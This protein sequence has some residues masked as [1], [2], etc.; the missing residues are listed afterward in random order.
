MPS[1]VRSEVENLWQDAVEAEDPDA[2]RS[3]DWARLLKLGIPQL[4]NQLEF[5]SSL[6]ARFQVVHFAS[7]IL[8]NGL[9]R[10]IA[11]SSAAASRQSLR[12]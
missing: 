11:I 12:F 7:R 5:S 3:T 4:E 8:L 2:E 1:T 6:T 10:S 9:S